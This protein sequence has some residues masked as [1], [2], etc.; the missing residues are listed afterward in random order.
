[1]HGWGIPRWPRNGRKRPLRTGIPR[2][3]STARRIWRESAGRLPRR[4]HGSKCG[5]AGLVCR[6]STST[7]T[8]GCNSCDPNGEPNSQAYGSFAQPSP[9]R[10][11][12]EYTFH[13]RPHM[14][15][16]I[17]ILVAVFVSFLAIFLMFFLSG[18][19]WT[20]AQE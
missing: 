6:E 10:L 17:A 11:E 7:R 9:D 1:M 12:E 14:G 4:R 19:Q 16:D 2:P 3:T 13:R 18:K 20:E 5:V 15:A 8:D